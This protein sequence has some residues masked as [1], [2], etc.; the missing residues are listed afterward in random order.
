MMH[1][2]LPVIIFACWPSISLG[3]LIGVGDVIAIPTNVSGSGNGTLDLRMFTFSGSEIEYQ[4]GTFDGD[5]AN[6]T[7]PHNGSS[8]TFAQSYVTTAGEIQSFYA[9]NFPNG[10][11]GSTVSEI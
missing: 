5:N 3:T 9:L 7:L 8:A 6:N 4:S 10:S 2:L 11:G 1:R